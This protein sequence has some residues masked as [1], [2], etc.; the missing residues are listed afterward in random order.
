M[1]INYTARQFALTPDIKK[2]CV[3]RM[4]AFEKL[5]GYPVEAN[6]ILSVE[7][8][9]NKVDI[10]VKT[11]GATLNAVEETQD[12]FSSLGVA[13][14]NIERRLKK[15]K[16]KLRERKRRKKEESLPSP[17][18]DSGEQ[19]KRVIRSRRYSL[20]PMSVEEAVMLFETRKDEVFV[21]R[22]FESEKWAVLFR[23][24]DGNF[25]LIEPE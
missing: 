11:K 10:N 1:N 9:R 24:K 15:E 25:G 5:L 2:Y 18:V 16:E 21:F 8:Y 20:K 17:I 23:R 13:F 6:L 12:M 19:S 14:D 22:N 4:T 3:R 7:K